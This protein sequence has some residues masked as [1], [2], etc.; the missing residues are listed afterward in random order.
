MDRKSLFFK[1][2]FGLVAS[3]LVVYLLSA[4]Q[5]LEVMTIETSNPLLTVSP[6]SSFTS[7]ITAVLTGTPAPTESTDTTQMPTQTEEKIVEI[8]P[9]I[10]ERFLNPCDFKLHPIDDQYPNPQENLDPLTGTTWMAI[11]VSDGILLAQ[12]S[13]RYWWDTRA[14]SGDLSFNKGNGL[15]EVLIETNQIKCEGIPLVGTENLT[16]GGYEY[17]FKLYIQ[18]GECNKELNYQQRGLIYMNTMEHD[19][20]SV[21]GEDVP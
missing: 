4:C 13:Y 3:M 2:L 15:C 7:T 14:F 18:N 5:S 9:A 11:T 8:N 6:L 20:F 16:T 19:V 1:L 17:D 21:N 10:V 12:D